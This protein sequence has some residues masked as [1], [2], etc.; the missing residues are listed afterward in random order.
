MKTQRI[1]HIAWL[2]DARYM[3][4]ESLEDLLILNALKLEP[5]WNRFNRIEGKERAFASTDN[6]TIAVDEEC[7]APPIVYILRV[8]NSI[9]CHAYNLGL[10]C[11]DIAEHE[12]YFWCIVRPTRMDF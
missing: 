2:N 4:M 11:L 9:K 1:E 7:T 3:E 10:Y 6:W 5:N 12:W 8:L